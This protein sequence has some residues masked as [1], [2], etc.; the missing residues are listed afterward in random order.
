MFSE[1]K[2]GHEQQMDSPIASPVKKGFPFP[3]IEI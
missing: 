1:T 2:H 3:T